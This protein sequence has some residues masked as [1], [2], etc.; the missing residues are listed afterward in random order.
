MYV[1]KAP[2]ETSFTKVGIR[3][4]I[5]P[6]KGITSKIGYCLIETAKGHETKIIEH[7]CDFNYYILKGKGYFEI[8]GQKESCSVG[9][10]VVIP[11]G[12]TFT[13]KGNLEMGLI[14]APPFWPEQEETCL[15]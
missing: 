6:I 14:T 12:S 8:N 13:Y 10:L 4:K 3:G 11:A 1:F 7:E 15:K 2:K 9:D 5:F